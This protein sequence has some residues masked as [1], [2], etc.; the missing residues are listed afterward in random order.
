MLDEQRINKEFFVWLAQWFITEMEREVHGST[1]QHLTS[2]A[3]GSF[4]VLVPPPREQN[5]I[6]S[7]LSKQVARVDALLAAKNRLLA[8]IAEKRQSLTARAVTLGL[9][10]RAPLRKTNILGLDQIPLHWR[11]ERAKWLFTERDDRT[12]TGEET[13]L[14]LRMDVG[15]IPH[16]EVSEK[17]THSEDLVGYKMASKGE[18]VLNRMRAAS[19]LVAVAPQD[20]LVS[21]DYAVFK[22]GSDVDPHFF[23]HLF[24]TNLMQT[25][26]RSE[27]TGLGTGAS[28]FLRLYS[29]NFLTLSLPVPPLSEQK[30]IV[31]YITAESARLGLLQAAA[32][33]TIAMLRERRTALIAAAVTGQLHVG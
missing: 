12:T 32:E 25:V 29:E 19:G 33:T 24:K 26:F 4:P 6:S 20:G 8:L 18:I 9:D 5:Q 2:D 1:M 13:L 16:N 23:A 30:A 27:S 7:Y 15:L 14:S 11:T 22:A 3:F 17:A 21:P 31:D 10:P 28:G